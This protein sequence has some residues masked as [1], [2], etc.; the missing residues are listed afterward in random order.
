MNEPALFRTVRSIVTLCFAICYIANVFLRI[1]LLSDL[2]MV[3]MLVVLV[4]SALVATGSSRFI[5]IALIAISVCL[6][7]Y[8]Q[9]P[10]G[11]WER[12]LGK[13]ADLIVMFI[14]IPLIGIPVQHGGYN[15][16]LRG[17]FARYANSEGRYYALVSSM[18]AIVGS[19]ISIAAVPLTF[20]VSRASRLSAN[21]R[22][23]ASALTRGFITCMIW[24]PTSAT[25]ALVVSVTSADW[26]AFAPFA[27]ACA[28]IA[29]AIGV[30][31]TLIAG[32]LRKGLLDEGIRAEPE[33]VSEA[34]IDAR[35]VAELALFALLLIG[36]IAV[37]SQ[38]FGLSA[39]IVVAMASL[40]WPAIWMLAIRRFPS[41]RSEFKGSYFEGKLPNAKNQVVLFTGAGM[42]AQSIA[43]SGLGTVIVDALMLTTGQSALLLTVSIIVITL[44]TCA[45]GI[46][47]IVAVAVIGGAIDPSACGISVG[48]LALVLSMSWALG[49]VICPAS[50]NVI[51]VADM[52]D[53]SPMEVSLKWS[54][55]YVAVTAA[56]FVVFVTVLRV[57]GLL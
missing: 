29:E 1:Q 48:Y 10:L 20:E 51:A 55:G 25:I 45:L 57:A 7:L 54:G 22:L 46:H 3:L 9:A 26:I 21:K 11:E 30:A 23:L 28:V 44:L 16:S 13:N 4:M 18:A 36:F 19:L 32:R 41:Y 6:L 47:P 15:D 37:I 42:L 27:I 17:L 24:A 5:G 49:N 43:Y 56:V 35:K 53:A 12:A 40:A 33:E 52:V 34:R 2:N 31:M 14:L 8:A 50:A 39:I 38:A